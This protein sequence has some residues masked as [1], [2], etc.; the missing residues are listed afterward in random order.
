MNPADTGVGLRLKELRLRRGMTQKE[1]SGDRI[2]RNMLSLIESGSASPSVSTL[3]Y[4][5][6]RLEVKNADLVDEQK[7]KSAGVP[8]VIRPSKESVQV[9]VG[10]NVQFVAEEF[11]K[12]CE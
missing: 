11:R 7:I 4:L 2:T 9:V 10:Q 8:G 3:L 6:E 1:L 12:L 5:A